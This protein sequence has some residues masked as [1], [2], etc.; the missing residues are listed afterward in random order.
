MRR[1]AP[2]L[3]LAAA[4]AGR[5]ARPTPP[6]APAPAEPPPAAPAE[7]VI[8]LEPLRV[9]VV[10]DERGQPTVIAVDARSLLDDGNEHL[11]G[12]RHDQ[13]LAH[14]DEL[15]RDFPDSSLAAPALYN[16][17]LA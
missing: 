2:L 13:A 14:Y 9:E 8:E 5:S 16:A 12:G 15:L 17:G 4:C 10:T 11:V 3:V 6:A 1:F 7:N